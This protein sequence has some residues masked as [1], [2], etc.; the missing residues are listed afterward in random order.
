MTGQMRVLVVGRV[1]RMQRNVTQSLS[2]GDNNIV[3][4]GGL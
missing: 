1:S 2:K 3:L 4:F